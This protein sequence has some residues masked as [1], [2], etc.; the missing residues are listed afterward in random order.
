VEIAGTDHNDPALLD[1]EQL[2]E[3]VVEL[4]ERVCGAA[5]P[6]V[7]TA[8]LGRQRRRD[9]PGHGTSPA[10]AVDSTWPCIGP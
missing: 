7:L 3:A 9:C 5:E 2:I 1:G 4:A 10:T 8:R 6:R